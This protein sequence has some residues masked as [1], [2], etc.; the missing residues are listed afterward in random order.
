MTHCV[1]IRGF[2]LNKLTITP[3]GITFADE[4]NLYI[5]R[6][7]KNHWEVSSHHSLLFYVVNTDQVPSHVTDR[8][9]NS[10][11]LLFFN[12]DIR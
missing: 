7:S 6:T 10:Y 3:D 11:K 12:K 1:K 9:P 2:T 5:Y 8:I 4:D